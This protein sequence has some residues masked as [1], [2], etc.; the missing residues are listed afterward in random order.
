MCSLTIN[1]LTAWE[2]VPNSSSRITLTWRNHGAIHRQIIRLPAPWFCANYP[3]DPY[4]P[5]GVQLQV[6][7]E[8]ALMIV[9]NRPSGVYD[10]RSPV[11][12]RFHGG[13]WQRISS[14]PKESEFTDLGSC[15]VKNGRLYA[16]DYEMAVDKG[17]ADPQRYWLRVFSISAKAYST[18]IKQDDCTR[19]RRSQGDYC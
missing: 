3:D 16:W 10:V 18:Q 5:T 7:G 1:H 9:A 8:P 13:V 17:H 12:Y 14:R 19:V 15:Y 4:R 2:T 11:F 6:S